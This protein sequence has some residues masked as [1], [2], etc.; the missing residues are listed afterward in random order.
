MVNSFS[1]TGDDDDD[2]CATVI[3]KLVLYITC[4]L[5]SR[6]YLTN[7]WILSFILD[8]IVT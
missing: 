5:M 1:V 2:N 8:K 4:D 3:I 6:I 7:T